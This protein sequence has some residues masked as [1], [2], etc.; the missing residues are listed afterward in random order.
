MGTNRPR[1]AMASAA[2]EHCYWFRFSAATDATGAIAATDAS[3]ATAAHASWKVRCLGPYSRPFKLSG[4]DIVFCRGG[5]G[6]AFRGRGHRG[7]RGFFQ[8]QRGR[9]NFQQQR[10]GRGG[11]GN[12]LQQQSPPMNFRGPPNRG[13]A[14]P[15]HPTG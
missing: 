11:R 10:G 2:R 14:G 1:G 7:G 12:F 3:W 15:Y 8:H 5:R 9:G 13:R 4:S 6:R